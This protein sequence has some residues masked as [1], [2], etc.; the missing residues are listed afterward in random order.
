MVGLQNIKVNAAPDN[1]IHLGPQILSVE[2]LNE[3]S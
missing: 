2:P 1:I 3:G